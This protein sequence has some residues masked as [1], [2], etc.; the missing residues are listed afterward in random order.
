MGNQVHFSSLLI[1]LVSFCLVDVESTKLKDL[2]CC[3]RTPTVSSGPSEAVK[4]VNLGE[5]NPAGD[6]TELKSKVEHLSGDDKERGEELRKAVLNSNDQLESNTALSQEQ[7]KPVS[8]GVAK[9]MMDISNSQI[10][11][12]VTGM[13][14]RGDYEMHFSISVSDVCRRILKALEPAVKANQGKVDKDDFETSWA[15]TVNLCQFI[16][17]NIKDVKDETY[18]TLLRHTW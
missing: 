11:K 2:F 5:T 18:V 8:A 1:C 4:T 10:L 14:P 16:L 15:Q 13:D 12:V 6:P 7:V 9:F 17:V 3:S